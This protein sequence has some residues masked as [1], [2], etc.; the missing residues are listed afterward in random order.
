MIR[1]SGSGLNPEGQAGLR[2][3]SCV[4]GARL[5]GNLRLLWGYRERQGPDGKEKHSYGGELLV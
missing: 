2:E 3:Q 5:G 4:K 1:D